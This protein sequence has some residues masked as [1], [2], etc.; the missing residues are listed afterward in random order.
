MQL[1]E[2]S[3]CGS[4]LTMYYLQLITALAL[5]GGTSRSIL[6]KV[7]YMIPYPK[8]CRG[9]YYPSPTHT[10]SKHKYIYCALPTS[11][12]WFAH[13]YETVVYPRPRWWFAAL[14]D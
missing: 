14:H 5:E 13:V 1:L 8:K 9:L 3:R 10:Y 7:A 2:P 6:P 12:T 4:L 11:R